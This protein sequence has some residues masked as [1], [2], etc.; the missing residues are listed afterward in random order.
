MTRSAATGWIS[1]RAEQA[2]ELEGVDWSHLQHVELE[3]LGLK[4]S[5]CGNRDI[6]LYQSRPYRLL[7]YELQPELRCNV[8]RSASGLS[9]KIIDIFLNGRSK[10]PDWFTVD[11]INLLSPGLIGTQVQQCFELT[12]ARRG[13]LALLPRSGVPVVLDRALAETNS[14][15]CRALRR[16]LENALSV[17][18]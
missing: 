10:K 4:P 6:W 7:G 18:S 2:F 12:L 14:R 13:P 8:Q 15:I 3:T 5:P 9:L 11:S 16:R 17:E 1:A